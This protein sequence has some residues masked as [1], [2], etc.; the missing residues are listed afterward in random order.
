MIY[1]PQAMHRGWGIVGLAGVVAA[2][3]L[4][5]LPPSEGVAP[6]VGG[7][8]WLRSETQAV[9][10]QDHLYVLDGWGGVHPV[11]TSRALASSASWP[12]KDIAFSLS[13]F[14]DGGGGYVMDGWGK[15]HPIGD[16]PAVDSGVYWPHWIGARQVALAPW[17]SA[18]APAGYV[19]DADGGLHAFGGAPSV[20]PSAKWAGKDLARGLVLLPF[21]SP[22]RVGGYTLDAYGGIHP[23]G[24]APRVVGQT[25]WKKDVARGMVIT[26]V[27]A[28]LF[29][30][31]YTLDSAGGLHPFGGAPAIAPSA[32][33]PGKDVADS[34]VAWTAAPVGRPGGWVLD[35]AGG[36]HEFG[37][38]PRLLPSVTWPGWDIA[39]GLA[40]AGSGGGSTER[41]VLDPQPAG[42]SFGAY[43]NQRDVRWASVPIGPVSYTVSQ[44]GCLVSA[45]AMVYSHFG[46]TAVTPTTIASNRTWFDGRGAMYNSALQIPGH[47]TVLQRNP[48]A[49]WIRSQLTAGRPVIVGMVL[50]G[51][52]THF[53]TLTGMKGGSDYWTNDPWEQHAMHVPFSGDWFTRGPIYE[54]FAFA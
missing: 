26:R 54:A 50:P 40:G 9:D 12:T 41:F 18:S 22:A 13:L 3:V 2:F 39:R 32:T 48:T 30:E 36:V 17:S 46:F 4:Y 43:F 34:I 15:L 52:G 51:G 25:V 37:S 27:R 42:D 7:L 45:L 31:G 38:A 5:L 35:R 11:G 21:G 14:P 24:V 20:D 23:F 10:N 19:L 53:V 29:V 47:T 8:A 28:G 6:A 1:H 49:A 44:I 16:A 33:W